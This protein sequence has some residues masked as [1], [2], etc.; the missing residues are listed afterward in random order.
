MM[1]LPKIACPK[2]HDCKKLSQAFRD[3][4]NSELL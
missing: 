2:F 4:K 1:V 3:V